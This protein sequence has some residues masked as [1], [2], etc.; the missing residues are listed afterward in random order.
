[1]NPRKRLMW[2]VFIGM[3]IPPIVWVFL[4][5]F[6][7][8]FSFDELIAIL[9]SLPMAIYMVI[10]TTIMIFGFNNALVRVETL[11]HGTGNREEAA[12]IISKLPYWFLIGQ[13]LYNS[14]GPAV[15]L[16]GKPFIAFDRFILAELA[17]LPLLLLFIIPVFI[18]F[19]IRLEEWVIRVPLSERYPFISFGKK[20]VLAIFTTVLGNIVLL[21]LL[22]AILLHSVPQLNLS[23]LLSKNIVVALIG[24]AI[25][26]LNITLLVAQVT[27]PVKNLIKELKTD[28][29]NLTK[30]FC[31]FTRDETGVMMNTLNRF[32]EEIEH[33][34]SHSKEIASANL[35]AARELDTINT[36]IN[37]RVHESHQITHAT[38]EQ[39]RSV[40]IIVDQGVSN[41]TVTLETMNCALEQLHHGKKELSTLLE[42]ILHSTQLEAELGN[43]LQQLNTEASQVRKILSVIGDIADQTNLLALNAAIEAARAGEHGRGFAVVADEVRQL[44]EKTQHSL[45][46]INGTINIIVQSISDAT[47]QMHH[48]TDAMK[49]VTTISERVD[50]DISAT[51]SAMEQTNTL[52]AQSVTNSQ[53]IARHIDSMLLQMEGLESIT[54]N[55]EKSMQELSTIVSQIATSANALYTQLGQFKTHQ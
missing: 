17:V 47:D 44:A 3:M 19:V 31:G 34:I 8:L 28:L 24:I 25:S 29:F 49:N 54:T 21:V 9:I 55:D 41:F 1:M 6:S 38:S 43:K 51:V 2:L 4:L 10:A 42:T 7:H 45:V 36:Q 33:S 40:Q 5:A 53:T 35:D 12:D 32:V 26:A 22:N 14:L 23:T 52:T 16:W 15:V 46:E 20:M 27:R 37:K 13:L 39:A 18:L 50:K 30:S 48:N 11:M